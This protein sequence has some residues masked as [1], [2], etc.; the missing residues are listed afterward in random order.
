MPSLVE[1]GKQFL[2]PSSTLGPVLCKL[3]L[4]LRQGRGGRAGQ[5][6]LVVLVATKGT[7]VCFGLCLCLV[8][9]RG[10][11]GQLLPQGLELPTEQ[12]LRREDV[13]GREGGREG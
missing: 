9:C 4:Y 1:A 10:G 3:R 6:A 7:E 13:E 8:G 11:Q 12:S 2:V 5:V